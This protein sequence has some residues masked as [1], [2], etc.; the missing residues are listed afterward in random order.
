VEVTTLIIPGKNDSRDEIL[1]LAKW[2][3]GVDRQIP[4]HIS[5]YHPDYKYFDA[6]PPV[7]VI[8]QLVAAA[9]EYLEYVYKGN[10]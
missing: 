10:C 6:P 1:G 3:S 5:R 2:L 7:S 8:D 4:L 9:S